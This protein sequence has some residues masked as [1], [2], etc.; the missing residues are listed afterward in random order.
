MWHKSSSFEVA[1]YTTRNYGH[2][3]KDLWVVM[4]HCGLVPVDIPPAKVLRNKYVIITSKRRNVVSFT[5]SSRSLFAG[6]ISFKITL[7]TPFLTQFD[8]FPRASEGIRKNMDT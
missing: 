7:L 4:F 5:Y 6:P 2:M 8:V 3:I 1:Y